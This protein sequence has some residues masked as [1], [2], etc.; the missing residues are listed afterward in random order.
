MDLN[1]HDPKGASGRRSCGWLLELMTDLRATTV[2]DRYVNH[3]DDNPPLFIFVNHNGR[4]TFKELLA[5][6]HPAAWIEFEK[7]VLTEVSNPREGIS[8]SRVHD[9]W[10]LAIEYR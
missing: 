4:L 7:G 8:S 6:K 1:G 2:L 9:F 3:T 5:S 10:F